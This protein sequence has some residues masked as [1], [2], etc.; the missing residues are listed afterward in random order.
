MPYTNTLNLKQVNVGDEIDDWGDDVN[1][2][3]ARID[4]ARNGILSI[5]V[6]GDRPLLAAT[7]DTDEARYAIINVVGGSGGRVFLPPKPALY[8]VRNGA[9]GDVTFLTEASGVGATATIHP[10]SINVIFCDGATVYQV[11]YGSNP[12]DYTDTILPAAKAYVD[13]TV[14]GEIN[15]EFPA[16]YEKAGFFLSTDGTTPVWIKPTEAD[17][18]G[19]PESLDAIRREC[20]GLA[21]VL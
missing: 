18:Q 5:A 19:L 17:I 10:S 13:A 8:T 20:I 12:K 1:A 14:F 4:D 11:G 3:W 16:Q 7:D 2:N 9:A 21:I 6:S 15:A